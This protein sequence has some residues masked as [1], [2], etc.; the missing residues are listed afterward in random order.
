MHLLVYQGLFQSVT[1]PGNQAFLSLS[2]SLSLSKR[3]V[4]Y[5]QVRFCI[6]KILRLQRTGLEL[7]LY[8]KKY[9]LSKIDMRHVRSIRSSNSQ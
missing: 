9:T 8:I 5:S 3:S 1:L 2:L 4:I 6:S 7:D